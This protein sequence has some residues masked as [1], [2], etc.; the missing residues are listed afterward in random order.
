MHGFW[1]WWCCRGWLRHTHNFYPGLTPVALGNLS[2]TRCAAVPFLVLLPEVL[3]EVAS[4]LLVRA[5]VLRGA[6]GGASTTGACKTG[7]GAAETGAGAEDDKHIL[8]AFL[9]DFY[10]DGAVLKP[11]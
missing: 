1:W 8:L 10:L 3:R 6:D 9:F 7:A 4:D 5:L 2:F 11:S